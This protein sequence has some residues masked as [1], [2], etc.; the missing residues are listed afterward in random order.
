MTK[1][2]LIKI[3]KMTRDAKPGNLIVGSFAAEMVNESY[4][5][6]KSM[7]DVLFRALSDEELG[8]KFVAWADKT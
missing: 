4:P 7:W 6:N 1:R 5:F 3:G 2:E 8:R